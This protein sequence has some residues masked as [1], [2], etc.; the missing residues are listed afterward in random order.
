MS[1]SSERV[2][3]VAAT[4]IAL[5]ALLLSVWS[6]LESR[7]HNRISVTPKLALEIET[8]TE[9]VTRRTYLATELHGSSG[10][11]ELRLYNSG[12]GP[13]VLERME[14]HVDGQ[15]MAEDGAGGLRQAVAQLGLDEKSVYYGRHPAGHTLR[16]GS[17][18][19][20]LGFYIG[21]LAYEPYERRTVF[22]CA[23]RRLGLR[24]NYESI[25]GERLIFQEIPITVE[26]R[27]C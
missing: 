9:R 13:A 18:A 17:H 10:S 12:L 4:V 19:L 1:R 6:G 7:R 14:V 3:S 16:E 27:K 21:G 24:I 23:L 26:F 15:K 5:A 11:A 25:Y 20:L 2:V 8:E 22:L